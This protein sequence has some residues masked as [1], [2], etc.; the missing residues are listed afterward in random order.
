MT[1]PAPEWTTGHITLI[2]QPDGS[3]SGV[4]SAGD[5]LVFELRR[6]HRN[7]HGAMRCELRIS[8]AARIA[9]ESRLE[10]W[11]GAMPLAKASRA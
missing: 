11:I 9:Y 6:G 2:D 10:A 3:V 7:A 8:A 4:V 1:G 5:E